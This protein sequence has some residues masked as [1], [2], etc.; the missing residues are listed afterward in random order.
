M[1]NRDPTQI[2]QQLMVHKE[3]EI[4]NIE[5]LVRVLWLVQSQSQGGTGSTARG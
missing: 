1:V 4:L 5:R 3:L 2:L